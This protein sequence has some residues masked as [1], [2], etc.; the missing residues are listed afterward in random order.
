MSKK[1]KII[2]DCDPGHD[3]AVA[4]IA[5]G[6]FPSFELLGIT[7]EAGN[8]TIEKT[9]KNALNI[10]QF[11]NLQIPVALGDGVPLK[12]MP[13]TCGEIHGESGLDGVEFDELKIDFDKRDAVTFLYETIKNNTDVTLVT[14][15]ALS[16][17]AKLLIRYPE[18]KENISEIVMM[19]GSIGAGNVTPAAEFNILCDPEAAEVVFNS[20][21][22]IKMCGLDVTREVLVLP[23]VI[24]RMGKINNK[25]STL[26]VDLMKFFNKTQKEVFGLDGGP[27]HD[28]VTI[29]SLINNEVVKFE[30]MNVEIDCSGGCSYGR[31]NCDRS[32]YL[33]RKPNAWVAVSIDVNKYWDEIENALR[34]Y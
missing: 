15:G 25:V 27:L 6:S 28:P 8:Q 18:V 24:E 20:G 34:R 31:T 10:V 12:R 7:V 5:A 1:R 29:I 32:G 13:I 17:I 9:G 4:I 3:D 2:I 33:K 26:F 30:F 19:G 22:N 16:N 23:D 11:L 21:L 14:T